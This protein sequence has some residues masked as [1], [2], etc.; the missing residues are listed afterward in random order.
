M[1]HQRWHFVTPNPKK[2][3]KRRLDHPAVAHHDD[4]FAR[5]FGRD[6]LE[7][8]TGAVGKGQP[9][10]TAGRLWLARIEREWAIALFIFLKR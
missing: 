1:K 8:G 3:A 9:G 2:V 7:R 10:F 5:V 6:A 4:D